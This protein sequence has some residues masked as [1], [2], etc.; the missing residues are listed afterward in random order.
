MTLL[1][2]ERRWNL[3]V[4]AASVAAAVAARK[5]ATASWSRFGNTEAPVNPADRE[6]TWPDALMWAV[7]AGS[8][9]GVARVMGRRGAAA[10]WERATG[11]APPGLR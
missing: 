5:L 1:T 9:A 7:F 3:V 4:G 6:A 11:S 2:T 8:L 10:V